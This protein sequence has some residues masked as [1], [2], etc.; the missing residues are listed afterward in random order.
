MAP[1]RGV[2]SAFEDVVPTS[3]TANTHPVTIPLL[4]SIVAGDLLVIVCLTPLRL[5]SMTDDDWIGVGPTFTVSSV[6]G[7][8]LFWKVA[9]SADVTAGEVDAT[10]LHTFSATAEYPFA[11]VNAAWENLPDAEVFGGWLPSS[12]NNGGTTTFSE[13]TDFTDMLI[14]LGTAGTLGEASSV[15]GDIGFDGVLTPRFEVEGD[16]SYTDS[17]TKHSSYVLAGADMT[18]T[19]YPLATVPEMDMTIE[20]LASYS[21]Y[22]WQSVTIGE[23]LEDPGEEPVVLQGYWGVQAEQA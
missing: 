1:F 4:G 9:T 5:D 8:L 11:A 22:F 20:D 10:V 6:S 17:G 3:T 12:V 15:N 7:R 13:T 23:F 14:V 21:G 2:T 18:L 19:G 16:I